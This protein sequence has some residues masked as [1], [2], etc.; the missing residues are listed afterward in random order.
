MKNP[1]ATAA[2]SALGHEPRLNVFRLIV[3]RANKGVTPSEIT[4]LLGLPA[5]TLSFHLKELSHAGLIHARRDG[6]Q[7][8]Y[9]PQFEFVDALISFLSENCCGGTPC[10]LTATAAL[11]KRLK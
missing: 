2:F 11:P 6:R 9:R 5:A 7:L 3:Q 4:E 1:Q 10:G 8:I